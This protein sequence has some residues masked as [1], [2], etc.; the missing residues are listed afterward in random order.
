MKRTTLVIS[1]VSLVFVG[2][3]LTATAKAPFTFPRSTPEAQGVS[4]AAILGFAEEAEQKLDALHSFMLV[5]HGTVVAE[6]WWSPYAAG[7]PHMLYSLSKSFTS[8]AV[9]LAVADGKLT[10]DD[11]V[12]K[13]FPLEAPSEPTANLRAMRVRD[14]LTMSTGH[15]NE[16]IL[17]FPFNADDSVVKA[18]LSKPVAHKPGTLFVYNTPASYML[19]AIVQKVTGQ[20]VV[21]YLRPRLFEPLGIA[22]PT[23]EASKQG[24]SMGGFGLSIRTEDIARFGQLYL[25][26]GEWQ[27]KPLIPAAWV[28]TATARQMSNG[29]SPSSDWEQG[30]GYQFWRSRHGYRGDGAHGQFCL[31]LPQYD[32]V[33]AITSGTRDMASVMNLVWDRLLPAFTSGT[34]PADAQAQKQ[35]ADKLGRLVLRTQ[36]GTA[37][38][39]AARAF[40][41][42]TY[43]F[44]TNPQ[45]IESIALDAAEP[46][47]GVS[48]TVRV[49]DATHRLSATPDTWNKSVMTM[50]G[51]ADPIATS[52]GWTANDTYT[53]KIAR[54]RTPFVATYRL[55]FADDQL[56]LEIE[57]NVGAADARI[58]R[59]VGKAG[60]TVA[61][62]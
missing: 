49:A 54:Y 19:S 39:A 27:G 30:Y 4:S 28:E 29:S 56:N 22:N 1:L 35:L 18:F 36:T 3:T 37:P 20:A 10:V 25:Q 52:G 59:L 26:K 9:G 51:T 33:I 13:F 50:K 57:Q 31:V 47:G 32:A 5:R 41:G 14:L 40:V 34:L 6:G 60:S 45:A 61:G 2:L 24:V 38:S 43:T 16:D 23:W 11:P 12:L 48:L 53:F 58:S 7:E 8:T 62:R 15:H 42:K 17:D 46:N 44:P 55:R 21:D